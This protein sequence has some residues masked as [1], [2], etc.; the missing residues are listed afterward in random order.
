M[1]CGLAGVMW[2]AQTAALKRVLGELGEPLIV[3]RHYDFTPTEVRFGALQAEVMPL[4]RYWR[5]DGNRWQAVPFEEVSRR[6]GGN[7]QHGTVE[8]VCVEC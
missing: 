6:F 3:L 2:T 8:L 4:A 7:L 1:V 5:H